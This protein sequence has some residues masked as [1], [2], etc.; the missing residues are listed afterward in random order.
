M[1]LAF[2][3]L[4]LSIFSFWITHQSMNGYIENHVCTSQC[5]NIA[6][7]A[8]YFAMRITMIWAQTLAL[9]NSTE[10]EI[11]DSANQLF[12]EISHFFVLIFILLILILPNLQQ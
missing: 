4:F 3:I 5:N 10:N 12:H 2:F 9:I 8:E 7:Q 1:F 6:S 11:N